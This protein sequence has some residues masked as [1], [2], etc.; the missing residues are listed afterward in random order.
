[1]HIDA[2]LL[3]FL[4]SVFFC[5]QELNNYNFIN[6]TI[7]DENAVLLLYKFGH[8]FILFVLI[9]YFAIYTVRLRNRYSEEGRVTAVVTLLCFILLIS[10]LSVVIFILNDLRLYLIGYLYTLLTVFSVLLTTVGL[11]FLPKVS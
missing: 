9:A 6:I 3:I 8:A 4:I 11:M 2:V 7:C 1:M 10:Y 5:L